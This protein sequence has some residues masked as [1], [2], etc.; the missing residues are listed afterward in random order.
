[1][2]YIPEAYWKPM[3]WLLHRHTKVYLV[4]LHRDIKM[5]HKYLHHLI[6]DQLHLLSD[7]QEQSYVGHA[8]IIQ[9]EGN[10]STSDFGMGAI[11]AQS[12]FVQR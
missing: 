9:L 8:A 11:G 12:G 4:V 6:L 7:L 1:M 5:P 10:Q 2:N 3:Q